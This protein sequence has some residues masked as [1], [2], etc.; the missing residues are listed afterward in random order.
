MNHFLTII[1]FLF[2][3]SSKFFA[4]EWTAKLQNTRP[5]LR[6]INVLLP[7]S[8]SQLI[9]AL[10]N[11]REIIIITLIYLV[12][13]ARLRGHLSFM[14]AHLIR[15]NIPFIRLWEYG[16]AGA[17]VVCPLDQIHFFMLKCFFFLM[18]FVPFLSW[19]RDYGSRI[20][21]S[22][23]HGWPFWSCFV[24]LALLCLMS[25]ASFVSF[26]I[27]DLCH[28]R[29]HKIYTHQNFPIAFSNQRQTPS[30]FSS[31]IVLQNSI[32]AWYLS[33]TSNPSQDFNLWRQMGHVNIGRLLDSSRWLL[34]FI[35]HEK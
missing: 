25:L 12:L 23:N 2:C 21:M 14:P 8:R 5:R 24:V 33:L 4:P 1:V 6:D 30:K 19:L 29:W 11:K 34:P 15:F 10:G 16:A 22:R 35:A 27:K 20:L 3:F 17:L 26:N 32:N 7:Q 9:F 13:S 31:S 28:A 18:F